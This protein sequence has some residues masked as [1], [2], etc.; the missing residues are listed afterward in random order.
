MA[1]VHFDGSYAP[2][3][4]L[5]VADGADPYADDAV[6]IQTDW[7]HPSV[8]SSMG[9]IPC[10]CGG[11]DGTVDCKACGRTASDMIA[12]AYDFIRERDGESFPTLDEY[13]IES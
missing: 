12:E 11:T 4:F 13:L 2:C 3:G 8:A 1:F 10:E 5:I 7:D 6:L 9:W